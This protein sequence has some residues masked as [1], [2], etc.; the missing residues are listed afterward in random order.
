MNQ[1]LSVGLRF[2]RRLFYSISDYLVKQNEKEETSG[3][4][5]IFQDLYS[6]NKKPIKRIEFNLICLLIHFAI[7]RPLSDVLVG[8]VSALQSIN[9]VN[10]GTK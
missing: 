7:K 5:L 3:G 9:V 10:K 4:C 8:Y 1:D 2:P 6:P